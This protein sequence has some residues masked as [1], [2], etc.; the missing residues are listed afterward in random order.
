MSY[1]VPVVATRV[2]GVPDVITH[3]KTGFLIEPKN[4]K[5]IQKYVEILL[6]DEKLRK[7]LSENC[8]LEIQKYS[9]DKITK[10]FEDVMGNSQERYKKNLKKKRQ[11]FSL[12]L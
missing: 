5:E 8:L 9:W 4:P 2:G 6:R 11:E 12:K 10:K 3:G 7:K 1:G